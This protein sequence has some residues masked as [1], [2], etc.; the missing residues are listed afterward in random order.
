[1][2]QSK[3]KD[4]TDAFKARADAG[5]PIT[6]DEMEEKVKAKQAAQG[7]QQTEGQATQ[8]QP[9]QGGQPGPGHA[10]HGSNGQTPPHQSPPPGAAQGPQSSGDY[11]E[12]ELDEL[13]KKDLEY[14]RRGAPALPKSMADERSMASRVRS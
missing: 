8:G 5:R 7:Q 9:A 3:P 4:I 14:Y 2:T 13:T 12:A 10:A 1:M 6:A 11:T